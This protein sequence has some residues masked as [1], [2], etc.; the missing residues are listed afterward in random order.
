MFYH[1]L[2]IHIE[3]IWSKNEQVTKYTEFLNLDKIHDRITLG[4]AENSRFTNKK[5]IKN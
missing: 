2:C 5:G 3:R 4:F 1:V